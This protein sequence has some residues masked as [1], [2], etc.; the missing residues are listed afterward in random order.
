MILL[1]LFDGLIREGGRERVGV[2][3]YAG[4]YLWSLSCVK[5]EVFLFQIS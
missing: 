4:A 1:D 5:Y 3:F 2:G